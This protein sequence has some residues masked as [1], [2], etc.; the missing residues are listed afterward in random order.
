[1]VTLRSWLVPV[2]LATQEA[3]I[4]SKPAQANSLQ[5]PILK[6]ILHK[7]KVGGVAEG[8]GPEFKPQY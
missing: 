3:E 6:K 4:S 7:N 2:V 5:G 8:E 1:M